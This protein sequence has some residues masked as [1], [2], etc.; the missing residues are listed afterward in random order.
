M[1]HQVH[2]LLDPL[3]T[4]PTECDGM[5]RLCHTVLAQHQIPHTVYFGVCRYQSQGIQPHYWIDLCGPWQGW[6]VDYRLRL[7]FSGEAEDLPHG[8]F[9]PEQFPQVQY[10]GN[11]IEWEVCLGGGR[12]AKLV[13]GKRGSIRSA[14]GQIHALP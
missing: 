8:V 4:S 10:L 3:D 12:G 2:S 6:R 11:P 5:T 13:I 7:W 14:L 9:Q 1:I